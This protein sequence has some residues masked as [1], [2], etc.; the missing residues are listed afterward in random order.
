MVP[1]AAV[2]STDLENGQEIKTAQGEDLVVSTTCPCA[3]LSCWWSGRLPIALEPCEWPM[4]P[5]PTPCS[6]HPPAFHLPAPCLQVT[7]E[8][9]TVYLE[10]AAGQ[11]VKVI[12]ADVIAGKAGERSAVASSASVR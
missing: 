2:L 11:K 8:D 1:D 6:C 7:I 10:T 9:G 4:C 5:L 12:A 3:V